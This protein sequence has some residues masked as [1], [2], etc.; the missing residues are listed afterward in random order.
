MNINVKQSL[1]LCTYLPLSN[2]GLPQM[3]GYRIEL[4]IGIF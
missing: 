2:N 3:K 1:A 4:L